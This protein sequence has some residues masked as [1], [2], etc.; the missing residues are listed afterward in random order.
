MSL[1]AI[2]LAIAL[3]AGLAVQTVQPEQYHG[4]ASSQY[5]TSL[6]AKTIAALERN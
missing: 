2:V 1:P 6:I 5:A 4:E 3:L